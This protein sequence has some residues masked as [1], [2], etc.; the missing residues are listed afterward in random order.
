MPSKYGVTCYLSEEDHKLFV[1]ATKKY[2]QGISKLA[3]EIIHAW[4]FSNKLQLEVKK[5]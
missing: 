2:K 4:L 3:K 5:K 1:L